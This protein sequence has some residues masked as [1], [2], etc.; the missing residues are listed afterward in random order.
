ML[1][2]R[3][4][5]NVSLIIGRLI[6]IA[7]LAWCCQPFLIVSNTH[8]SIRRHPWSLYA[9]KKPPVV[10]VVG[11]DLGGVVAAC[12]LAQQQQ[13]AKEVWLLTG[14]ANILHG[15]TTATT[16]ILPDVLTFQENN[17]QL[18]FERYGSGG[19]EL[20][21]ILA[22][23]C[24][25]LRAKQWLEEQ[26]VI[27]QQGDPGSSSSIMA[28]LVG[29]TSLFVHPKCDLQQILLKSLETCQVKIKTNVK[30][31][32]ISCNKPGF[33]IRHQ[34]NGTNR[35]D[36]DILILAGDG[37]DI[38]KAPLL[39]ATKAANS[40]PTA[41]KAKKPI[42]LES[43]MLEMADEPMS[44]KD[45]LKLEKQRQGD[46]KRIKMDL[47]VQADLHADFLEDLSKQEQRT[48]AKKRKKEAKK[49]KEQQKQTKKGTVDAVNSDNDLVED[50][51]TDKNVEEDAND[52]DEGPT[53][54]NSA[55][56]TSSAAI[57]TLALA[58][59]LGHNVTK[60]AIGMFSFMVNT[61]GILEGC[62]KSVVPKA[63]VRCK[64]DTPSRGRLPKWDGPLL[65]S[66]GEVSGPAALRLSTLIAHEIAAAGNQGTLQIHFAPDVGGV[67]EVEAALL[68]A[69]DPVSSVLKSACPLIHREVDY[70]DYDVETGDF[71]SV[72]F[73]LVPKRLWGNLCRQ[74]GI[75]ASKLK[76]KDLPP[77]TVQALAR[78]LVD[79]PLAITGIRPCENVMAGGVSLKEVNMAECQSQKVKGLFL[80]G[81]VIDVHGFDG[82]FNPLASLASGYV[83]GSHALYSMQEPKLTH[84]SGSRPR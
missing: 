34:N 57:N 37:N 24:T 63:R 54:A 30:M 12:T 36:V 55:I 59:E 19:R 71:R 82:G 53:A 31:D 28:T 21:G 35:L 81:S 6:I 78:L 44:L 51:T 39:S 67:E 17:R 49:Q 45:Q 84:D 50:L 43:S 1:G 22:K 38:P 26:G 64:V 41:A 74:A 9:E 33:T 79:S 69:A 48:L 68:E 11:G 60:E 16:P 13:S 77:A 29:E 72:E 25:P 47:M 27:L 73:P 15:F 40:S 20:A 42:A 4:S 46:A 8:S 76:W 58:T 2:Q 70:D 7:H 62:A 14:H 18:I 23:Q 5:G 65:V 3:R 80:C 61:R 83:V 75:T 52:E 32:S 66:Q 10:A 56:T